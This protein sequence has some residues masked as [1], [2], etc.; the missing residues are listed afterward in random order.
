MTQTPTYSGENTVYI[1]IYD[2]KGEKVRGLPVSASSE[3]V[4][5]VSLSA[6]PLAA[7]GLN[8]SVITNMLGESMG[9]WDGKNDGGRIVFPG[10][11]TIQ[12]K[13]LD[14]DGNE[15]V[16]NVLIDIITSGSSSVSLKAEYLSGGAIRIF[17]DAVN[18][19][20]L[21]IK[22]YNAA[23]ELI[24]KYPQSIAGSSYSMNWA[25]LTAGGSR[26][27]SGIY[28]VVAEYVDSNTLLTGRRLIRAAVLR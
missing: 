23:G 14:K 25:G 21:D 12:I 19:S 3:I 5:A 16:I 2:D 28:V 13:T 7:N 6:N 9:S 4:H 22:I 10:T 1:S 17:G 11:Y 8:A 18:V 26:V 15:F 27:S 20:R 24:G